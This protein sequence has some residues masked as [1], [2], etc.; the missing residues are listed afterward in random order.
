MIKSGYVHV[1][2][3]RDALFDAEVLV[4][5]TY[6]KTSYWPSTR[7]PKSTARLPYS[8]GLAWSFWFDSR[9]KKLPK[10]GF[11][12]S[13]YEFFEAGEVTP[14]QATIRGGAKLLRKSKV[15][16]SYYWTTD[17]DVLVNYLLLYGPVVVGTKWHRGMMTTVPEVGDI[18]ATGEVVGSNAYLVDGVNLRE[19]T[20]RLK[21]SWGAD[22]GRNG[23]GYLPLNDFKALLED[24]GEACLPVGFGKKWRPT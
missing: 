11:Y 2:D 21:N 14:G 20:I 3:P 17:V 4:K 7:Q 9:A 12:I 16:R 10:A 6:K 23:W 24:D 13:P 22:W 5:K 19:G 18:E 8:P 15:I 1:K